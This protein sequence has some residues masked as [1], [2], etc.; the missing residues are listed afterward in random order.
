VLTKAISHEFIQKIECHP[1]MGDEGAVL[2]VNTDDRHTI[3]VSQ[4]VFTRLLHIS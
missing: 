4:S 2:R 3:R 1:E